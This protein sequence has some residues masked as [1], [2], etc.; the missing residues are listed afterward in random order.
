LIKSDDLYRTVVI[1]YFD[2]IRHPH[3]E[4]VEGSK[5]RLGAVFKPL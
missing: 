2:G 4:R 5:D 3:L 1:S